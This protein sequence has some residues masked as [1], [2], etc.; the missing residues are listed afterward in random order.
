MCHGGPSVARVPFTRRQHARRPAPPP[1]CCAA[2]ILWPASTTHASLRRVAELRRFAQRAAARAVLPAP[3][4]LCGA[5]L[6]GGTPRHAGHQGKATTA[7]V[8]IDSPSRRDDGSGAGHRRHRRGIIAHII[9]PPRDGPVDVT[10]SV[11]DDPDTARRT[12]R[13]NR[14]TKHYALFGPVARRLFAPR[15]FRVRHCESPAGVNRR[16]RG[17]SPGRLRARSGSLSPAVYR[18]RTPF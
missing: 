8:L 4:Q 10:G 7:P 3:I 16:L 18:R 6:E 1:E 15:A 9:Q 13:R 14:A 17:A 2:T 5:V 11:S 12:A